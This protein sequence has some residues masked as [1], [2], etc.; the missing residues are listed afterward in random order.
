MSD[1]QYIVG[2]LVIGQR[3]SRT[4]KPDFPPY[5]PQY[6]SPNAHFKFDHSHSD[7]PLHMFSAKIFFLSEIGVL[8]VAC[9]PT[10][11][12]VIN[13]IKLFLIVANF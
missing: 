10:K 1:I 2:N 8:Q 4:V 13:D 6:T 3:V 5:I 9:H 11:C 7:A 12:D